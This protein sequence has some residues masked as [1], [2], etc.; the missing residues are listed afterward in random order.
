[1]PQDIDGAA[2]RTHDGGIP[3]ASLPAEASVPKGGSAVN[4]ASNVGVTATAIK[5]GWFGTGDI[6]RV[7]EDGYFAIADRRKDL[8]IRRGYNV[9]PREIEEVL[10]EHPGRMLK[11]EIVSRAD[12]GQR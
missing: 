3:T 10:H 8:I 4:L 9:Y 1:L 12:L 6:G 2:Q 5:D 7:D 11:R